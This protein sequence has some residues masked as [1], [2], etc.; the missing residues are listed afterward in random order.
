MQKARNNNTKRAFFFIAE[1]KIQPYNEKMNDEQKKDRDI[2]QR[3]SEFSR[4]S[5]FR[6]TA[7]HGKKTFPFAVYHGR[8]PEW[9]DGFPLHWHDE[10]EIIF[11]SYG[12]GIVTVQGSCFLCCEGDIVLIPPGA[13]HS[14]LQIGDDCIAYYNILFSISLLEENPDS[15]CSR[16]FFSAF[17][18]GAH[19]KSYHYKKGSPLNDALFPLV[20]E[21]CGLW[22]KDLSESALLVK[23]RLFEIMH[24]INGEV[25]SADES[26]SSKNRAKRLKKILSYVEEHFSSR[27][28]VEDAASLCAL[29]A[30]RFMRIFRKETGM[31]FVQYVND[32]RLESA[33]EQLLSSSGTVTAIAFENGFENISYF[34]RLFQRKFGCPPSEYRKRNK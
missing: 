27:I 25:L 32:Y 20:K 30:S 14:I 13:V 29:S 7:S 28:T 6:E 3:K 16:R 1:R 31:S 26:A 17:L 2:H 22:E 21:L 4:R 34:I 23:A 10:F 12:T 33:G 9:L 18:D 11:V 15:F 19:L 5:S 24:L 8:I